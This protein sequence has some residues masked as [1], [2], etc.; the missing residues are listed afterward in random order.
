MIVKLKN[1][2]KNN[3][4]GFHSIE[5]IIIASLIIALTAFIA[6][7]WVKE[8]K[9]TEKVVNNKLSTINQD[10][11]TLYNDTTIEVTR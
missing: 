11:E 5:F 6:F 2:F 4:K 7:L 8:G 9:D 3:N 10:L 1:F